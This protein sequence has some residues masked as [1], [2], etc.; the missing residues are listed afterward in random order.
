MLPKDIG[1]VITYTGVDRNSVCVDA[2]TGSG[3]LAISLAR[4]CKKVTS[5]DIRPE[6]IKIAERNKLNEKLDNLELKE[7]DI[8]KGIDEKDVDLVTLDM[9]NSDRENVRKTLIEYMTTSVAMAPRE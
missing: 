7:K 1:L 2:G 4:I 6:F 8:T 9:P 5:Y 3:W